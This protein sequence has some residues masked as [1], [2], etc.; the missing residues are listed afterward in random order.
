MNSFTYLDEIDND[1]LADSLLNRNQRP[2]RFPA[3][4]PK[5]LA[6]SERR[7]VQVQDDSRHSF[8]FTYKAARFEEGW[9]L[10]SLGG[11][12]EHQWISDVLK[13]VKGGKEAS[14]YLCRAGAEVDAEL[15]AVKVYRPRS[16]RNLKNDHAYREGR[17]NLDNEGRVVIN[18]G[19]LH[20]MEK[21]TEYGKNLLHQS[22][23]AYEFTCLQTLKAAGA[24][25]PVPYEMAG[26]AIL[27]G[28]IGDLD[29]CA[30]TL[31][32]ISLDRSEAQVLFERVLH[33][34][35]ILLDNKFIHGDLS[36]YNILF[37]EGE[38]TLIDFPQVVS[39]RINRNAYRI[40]QRDV[41]RVCEY[42]NKQGLHANPRKVA[43]EIWTKHGYRAEPEVDIRLLDADDP[44]DRA[45][46]KKQKRGN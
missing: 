3:R 22:W 39:P 5:K 18:D 14:V 9:L 31:S 41:T 32:E 21:K 38:I 13:L 15:V 6:A 33:N 40:F 34:I 23:I 2:Q 44:Q 26:N 35:D 42:F 12:Y 28:Y 27:M 36:A 45:F 37:W 11:F 17:E 4:H 25:V 8:K 29:G 20:A 1:G 19:M 24:D 10:D 46:W 30:P 7:F 43:S 16:M